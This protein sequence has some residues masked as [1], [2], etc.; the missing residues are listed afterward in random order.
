MSLHD[1]NIEVCNPATGSDTDSISQYAPSASYTSSQNPYSW[2]DSFYDS[3]GYRYS[4][5]DSYL[6]HLDCLDCSLCNPLRFRDS[7][8][9]FA[10]EYH[11]PSITYIES[12][13]ADFRASSRAKPR[14]HKIRENK[15]GCNSYR[16]RKM[17]QARQ[18]TKILKSKREALKWAVRES[19][20][21]I[22]CYRQDYLKQSRHRFLQW[23]TQ[24]EEETDEQLYDSEDDIETYIT[25]HR[26][27]DTFDSQEPYVEIGETFAVWCQQRIAEMRAVKEDGIRRGKPPSS[28]QIVWRRKHDWQY[29]RMYDACTGNE[30]TT[31][32][33]TTTY[34]AL[35][36][37]LLR[38]ILQPGHLWTKRQ[39]V[40]NGSL[41]QLIN[42][43]QWLGKFEWVWRGN[44][45]GCWEVEYGSCK[46]CD[47][48]RTG[49]PVFCPRC[50]ALGGSDYYESFCREGQ[51]FSAPEDTQ[52]CSL[53]E[54]VGYEGR[55]IIRRDE[56]REE[57]K[58][59]CSDD[60]IEVSDSDS[61]CEWE[62]IS[63][64][65]SEVW[66]VVDLL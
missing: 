59:G 1:T 17:E 48:H 43:Y 52:R 57:A 33:P 66:S 51:C 18:D 24:L 23:D 50:C 8:I 4:S 14:Q 53:I 21:D 15:P 44:M 30:S 56:A 35:G 13:H 60:V 39:R 29:G 34:D 28:K 47:G 36:H 12:E 37:E 55:D 20:R 5:Q 11:F 58:L 65:S 49:D 40:S 10:Q 3:Q 6:D 61:G 62:L 22:L 38:F 25:V 42:G 27:A 16:C 45:S 9:A 63:S 7:N 26:G 46:I 19:Q 2:S 54:W 64:A 32:L 41:F 31:T